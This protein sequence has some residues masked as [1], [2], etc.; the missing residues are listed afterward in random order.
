MTRP[1]KRLANHTAATVEVELYS[2]SDPSCR[3]SDGTGRSIQAP[4]SSIGPAGMRSSV[5]M[6]AVANLTKAR[7]S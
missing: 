2:A 3:K 5:P 7:P 6:P 1:A 4:K